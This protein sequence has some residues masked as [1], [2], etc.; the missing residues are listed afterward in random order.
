MHENL[1]HR[2]LKILTMK[3]PFKSCT[4]GVCNQNRIFLNPQNWYDFNIFSQCVSTMA[5]RVSIRGL[6]SLVLMSFPEK[7]NIVYYEYG[8]TYCK[9]C[10][11]A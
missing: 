9:I 11:I 5:P 7:N 1:L 6:T 8:I 2:I 10:Q 3:V 4:V